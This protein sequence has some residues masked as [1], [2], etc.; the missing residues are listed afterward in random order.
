MKEVFVVAMW[1]LTNNIKEWRNNWANLVP[2]LQYSMEIRKLIYTT[3]M[4]ENLNRNVRKFTKNKTMFP[5][6]NE[7]MKAVCSAIQ[8]VMSGLC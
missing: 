1:V 5:D 7:V 8:H 4:I 2:F 3:N 6:D